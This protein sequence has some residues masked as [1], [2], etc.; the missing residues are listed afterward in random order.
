MKEAK[1]CQMSIEYNVEIEVELGEF[2]PGT[3]SR[4]SPLGLLHRFYQGFENNQ[5]E[6]DANVFEIDKNA[7]VYKMA[8]L[9]K[10]KSCHKG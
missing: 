3:A 8:L 6:S 5:V 1:P 10:K 2:D 9:Y 4:Y 7:R